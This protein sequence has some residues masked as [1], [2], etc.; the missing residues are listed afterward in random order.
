MTN[1][2]DM[3]GSEADTEILQNEPVTA[4]DAIDDDT[5]VSDVEVLPGTGGPDDVGDIEVDPSELNL[6]GDSIPG[7]PK[8]ASHPH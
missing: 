6:S 2:K 4:S 5:N 1:E 8:P 7:H 3:P